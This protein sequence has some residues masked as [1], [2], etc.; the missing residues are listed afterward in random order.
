MNK[1]SECSQTLSQEP[2]VCERDA[3]GRDEA[4]EHHHGP[5]HQT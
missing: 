3:E 2:Q 1:P 4:Q 5:Q